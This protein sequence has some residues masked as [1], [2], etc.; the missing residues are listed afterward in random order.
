MPIV[1]CIVASPIFSQ[2]DEDNFN[3]QKEIVRMK[4]SRLLAFVMLALLVL[5]Q[6]TQ[7][8]DHVDGPA[9]SADPAADITD[10]FAWMSPDALS[11]FLAMNLVRNATPASR[12]SDSVQYVFHTTSRP[13]FA[14]PPSAEITIICTFN[15][16]QT[17][18]CWVG[19]EDYVTGDASNVSGILSSDGKVRVFAGLRNDP[20]FFNLA[21]L[22]VTGRTVAGLAGT[23]QLDAAGC[24]RLDTA[25]STDLVN[26]LSTAPGG[27]VAV[28]NFDKFNVLSIVLAIDKT[29]VTKN[30]PILSVAG[31]TNRP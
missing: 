5:C 27:G 18:Q 23:L 7:S 4:Q 9:A 21:G 22:R 8:A 29:L 25:T 13:T 2:P 17:I 31:S 6:P 30:G 15:A 11:V 3:I 1:V 24:P 28:N 14:S 19:N 26:K 16:A 12:F 20:F 10:V